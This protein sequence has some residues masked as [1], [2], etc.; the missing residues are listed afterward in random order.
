MSRSLKRDICDLNAPGTLTSTI[1]GTQRDR[2]LPNELQYACEF[3]VHHLQAVRNQFLSDDALQALVYDFLT[4]HFLHWL[5]AL[6][7][8]GKLSHGADMIKILQ[9]MSVVS[10]KSN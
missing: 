7:I 4:E 2:F 9:S 8:L 1:E 5:E 3:W 10:N 6:S